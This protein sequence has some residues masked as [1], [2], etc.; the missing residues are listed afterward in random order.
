MEALGWIMP[1]IAPALIEAVA[2]RAE[3]GSRRAD[4]AG[5]WTDQQQVGRRLG[6]RAQAGGDDVGAGVK[7]PI[8]AA[9]G[10]KDFRQTCLVVRQFQ[11]GRR[12]VGNP[13]APAIGHA[14]LLIR[15]AK[16]RVPFTRV[17]TDTIGGEGA[18][19]RPRCGLEL[20]RRTRGPELVGA[21]DGN[22]RQRWPEQHGQREREWAGWHLSGRRSRPLRC[23]TLEHAHK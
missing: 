18:A 6:P 10:L 12:R 16:V 17:T 8:R 22:D 23:R 15:V 14:G 5:R 21:Q 3:V 20:P 13:L 2:V 11:G 19:A 9:N 1:G 7:S 4:A